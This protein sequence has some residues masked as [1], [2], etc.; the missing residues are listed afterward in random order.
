[1]GVNEGNWDC[2]V[3]KWKFLGLKGPKNKVSVG[4]KAWG[5][6]GHWRKL[7]RKNGGK[8]GKGGGN[9][10]DLDCSLHKSEPL[11]LWCVVKLWGGHTFPFCATANHSFCCFSMIPI[12][13][14]HVTAV[15]GCRSPSL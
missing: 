13:G 8:W 11:G 14:I 9:G 7:P 12:C 2:L 15:S 6:G 3:E 10:G 5:G 4:N 1:M